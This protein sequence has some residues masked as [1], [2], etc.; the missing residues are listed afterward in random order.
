MYQNKWKHLKENKQLAS[1]KQINVNQKELRVSV[2]SEHLEERHKK[3][4]NISYM[5]R[6]T[7]LQIGGS[8]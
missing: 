6:T 4:S 8:R 5:H 1:A 2:F 3:T 7:N